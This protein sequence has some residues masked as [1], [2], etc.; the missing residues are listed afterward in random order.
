M[1][2]EA[3]AGPGSVVRT[4]FSEALQV[5]FEPCLLE[6][7]NGSTCL[8][9]FSP[10]PGHRSGLETYYFHLIPFRSHPPGTSHSWVAAAL[11]PHILCLV[12]K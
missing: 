3:A 9:G 1:S 7:C 12:S 2:P 10:D 6:F 5:A 8:S 4:T 11:S